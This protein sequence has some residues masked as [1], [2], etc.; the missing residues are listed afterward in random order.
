MDN[1]TFVRILYL[2][3]ILAALIGWA[4]VEFRQRMGL[5]LR[6]ALAWGMIFLALTGGYGLWQDIRNDRAALALGSS[7]EVELRRE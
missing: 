2:G 5:A 3:L 1:D 6:M 4:L 7:G